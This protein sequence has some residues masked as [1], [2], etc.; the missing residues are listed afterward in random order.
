[1]STK[2]TNS[3]AP[4]HGVVTLPVGVAWNHEYGM[5]DR[6]VQVDFA[7][8]AETLVMETDV[9]EGDAVEVL[10]SSFR[11]K[12][13]N[14]WSGFEFEERFPHVGNIMW[15]QI[16]MKLEDAAKFVGWLRLCPWWSLHVAASEIWDQWK[17]LDDQ[18]VIEMVDRIRWE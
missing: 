13:R 16:N 8:D 5:P 15:D 2:Q 17:T 12:G 6:L 7:G 1:M 4:V 9:L 14:A 11:I 18:S 10:A 3:T